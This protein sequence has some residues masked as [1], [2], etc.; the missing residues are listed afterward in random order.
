MFG[1]F[2]CPDKTCEET[3]TVNDNN[4]LVPGVYE[5]NNWSGGWRQQESPQNCPSCSDD[6]KWEND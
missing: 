1:L 6:W 4:Q 2:K 3:W 5:K